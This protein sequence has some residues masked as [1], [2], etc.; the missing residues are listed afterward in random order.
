MKISKDSIKNELHELFQKLETERDELKV[1]AHLTIAE[2]EDAWNT[3]ETK[4]NSLKSK[5]NSIDRG[6]ENASDDFGKGFKV[7]EKEIKQAYKDI[8]TGIKSS[9]LTK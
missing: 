6:V 7:L 8:R 5:L 1:K 2:L 9:Q 4:W 3:A